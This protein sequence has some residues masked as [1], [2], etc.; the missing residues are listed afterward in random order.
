MLSRTRMPR[1]DTMPS[2]PVIARARR[3]LAAPRG[4]GECLTGPGRRRDRH[5]SR[6]TAGWQ[7]L[8][9][10]AVVVQE[11]TQPASPALAVGAGTAVGGPIDRNSGILEGRQVGDRHRFRVV[12][13]VDP[14][15]GFE[16][17]VQRCIQS[18]EGLVVWSGL[19][20]NAVPEQLQRLRE[21]GEVDGC[22]IQ[23]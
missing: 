11:A 3:N 2:E 10:P 14:V 16:K 23:W 6:R 22:G 8:Q 12:R 19:S 20:G 7:I 21:V 13:D 17:L 1:T 4:S 15:Q 18:S 9:V 5:T